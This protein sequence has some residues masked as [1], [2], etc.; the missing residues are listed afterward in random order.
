[1]CC[2]LVHSAERTSGHKR[3]SSESRRLLFFPPNSTHAPQN[4][5]TISICFPLGGVFTRSRSLHLSLALLC[6]NWPSTMSDLLTLKPPFVCATRVSGFCWGNNNSCA[7]RTPPHALPTPSPP[8]VVLAVPLFNKLK[9]WLLPQ[10]E[11]LFIH[12]TTH[13][14]LLRDGYFCALAGWM[15]HSEK[16]HYRGPEEIRFENASA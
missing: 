5:S 4:Q 8:R 6:G 7:G 13:S 10:L 12:N 1:M 3:Q 14:G 16:N 11:L 2:D 15:L 9:L